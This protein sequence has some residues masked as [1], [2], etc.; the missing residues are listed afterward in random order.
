MRPATPNRANPP[1]RRQGRSGTVIV[2]GV[3]AASSGDVGSAGWPSISPYP[4]RRSGRPSWPSAC[5]GGSVAV[6]DTY[7]SIR[8]P[9][10]HDV[11]GGS[12]HPDR[13][14]VVLLR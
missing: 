2:R 4:S 12:R 7:S 1:N 9:L 3:P 10:R 8:W 5:A 13:T 14:A 6:E 11:G